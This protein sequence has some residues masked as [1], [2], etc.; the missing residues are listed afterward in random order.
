MKIMTIGELLV[1]L[2]QTGVNE[3]G[4]P[5]YS[6]N[7]GGAPANVAVAASLMGAGTA[8]VGRVG[9]DAFGKMLAETL[10]SKN[11][12]I[13]HLVFDNEHPTTLAIVSLD[14]RGERSFSFYRKD[15]ADVNLSKNDADTPFIEKFDIIHFGSVSLTDEPSASAIKHT[16]E[17]AKSMG[18][19][20]SYDPN[21]RPL[22]WTDEALAVAKMRALLKNIDIIKVSDEEALLLTGEDNIKSAAKSLLDEGI[23]VVL[24]TLGE[25]G[26]YYLTKYTDG[27]CPAY[28]GKVADTNGAG[29]TFLG[30][31]LTFADDFDSLIK[32]KDGSLQ[33][34][35]NFACAAAGL[36][37]RKSGAIPSM[38][39]KTEVEEFI[40]HSCK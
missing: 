31:F 21:Y 9:D 1:D 37:T 19:I 29:D 40:L 11:I 6:A 27:F 2:T 24:V 38:P 5:Q 33:K 20:V 39:T 30:T 3:N 16:V 8:F 7:P 18:K 34:A 26:A 25:K 22:L 17:T 32:N 15:S 28:T 13:S 36:S 14:S 4:I 35:V 23:S 12:D 10:I